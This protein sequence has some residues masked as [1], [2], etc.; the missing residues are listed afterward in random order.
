MTF[1]D[2]VHHEHEVA[3]ARAVK[4]LQ[5]WAATIGPLSPPVQRMTQR[6]MTEIATEMGWDTKYDDILGIHVVDVR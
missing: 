5:L 1:M 2:Q 3:A 4:Q 6:A